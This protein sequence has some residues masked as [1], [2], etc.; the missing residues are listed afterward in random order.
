[1]I[2]TSIIAL[3]VAEGCGGD[4]A[5]VGA[6]ATDGGNGDETSTG[7]DTGTSGDGSAPFDGSAP[8]D[9]APTGDA[10]CTAAAAYASRCSLTDACSTARV[11]A[12]TADEAIASAA[13][14]SAY[15]TCEPT[16]PCPTGA[17]AGAEKA[18]ADCLTSHYGTPSTTAHTLATDYCAKCTS[19]PNCATNFYDANSPTLRLLALN[20]TILDD[21]DKKCLGH[22]AGVSVGLMCAT[23]FEKCS[24][25]VVAAHDPQPAACKD[26]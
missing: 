14:I 22:D 4:D 2:F 26:Q 11:A 20:D 7:A 8:Q 25:D 24:R 19:G 1:L 15:E 10:Y 17:D 6:T 13:G 16:E 9:S 18:Y 5:S 21:I 23:D 12:C 3:P